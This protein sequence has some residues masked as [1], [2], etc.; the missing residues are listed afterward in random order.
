MT[1]N[2]P[3]NK[4]DITYTIDVDHFIT[5]SSVLSLLSAIDLHH[6]GHKVAFH[7]SANSD[8]IFC[9]YPLALDKTW[10]N[11][12][13]VHD[14]FTQCD[15]AKAHIQIGA[16]RL[17]FAKLNGH[18]HY[19]DQVKQTL[20]NKK[21]FE[22]VFIAV[23]KALKTDDYQKNASL[24]FI[25]HFAK[26]LASLSDDKQKI[27]MHAIKP[28]T[29]LKD[30]KSQ[31][32]TDYK[33]INYGLHNFISNHFGVKSDLTQAQFLNLLAPFQEKEDDNIL[34]LFGDCGDIYRNL[35]RHMKELGITI[36]Q[37]K[38]NQ[39][40]TSNFTDHK[41]DI[42]L[43]DLTGV[44]TT[45]KTASVLF[46]T[47]W[48][49]FTRDF[50]IEEQRPQTLSM[51]L[52]APNHNHGHVIGIFDIQSGHKTLN[53]ID[54]LALPFDHIS[55]EKISFVEMRD[56]GWCKT[57][58]LTLCTIKDHEGKPIKISVMAGPVDDEILTDT[59]WNALQLEIKNKI[60]NRIEKTVKGLILSFEEED[61][62]N[63]AQTMVR[64]DT[65]TAFGASPFTKTIIFTPHQLP[66]A[67]SKGT[68]FPNVIKQ[69]GQGMNANHGFITHAIKDW[70]GQYA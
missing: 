42:T 28:I 24:V 39:I 63:P 22:A 66:I 41:A 69:I 49:N 23:A 54:S 2:K 36:F 25:E 52:N 59:T 17:S 48:K 40:V 27:I 19:Q 15:L 68:I 16:D 32:P 20:E 31:A 44:Q 67:L 26:A 51:V 62:A 55:E 4:S 57:P 12:L 3:N 58:S 6:K 46:D 8:D 10:L 38:Y 70:L 60:K 33:E 14:Y 21:F 61:I 30:E 18:D 5:G 64:Y 34:W 50:I 47:Q 45:L 9:F 37:E 29:K 11:Q 43:K 53:M 1:D 13:S 7:L 56:E 35:L 65:G